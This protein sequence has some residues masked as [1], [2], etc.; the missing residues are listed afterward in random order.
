MLTLGTIADVLRATAG[1]DMAPSCAAIIVAAGNSLRMGTG[2]SKQFLTVGGVPVLA[3]TMLAFSASRYIDEIIVVARPEEIDAVWELQRSY[4]IPKISKVVAGG[5]SRSESVQNGFAAID[6]SIKYVAIHD[7][8][9]CLITPAMIKKVL[10]AAFLH[11]AASAACAVT[12]TVKLANKRGFI[13]KTVDRRKV[14]LAQTPQVFHADLYRAALSHA[15][16]KD[17]TDDNQLLE[18]VD[19]PVKLVDCGPENLK[20]THPDDLG[21]AE[22]ILARRREKA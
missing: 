11:R 13:E 5:A 17:L 10:R 8:A 20:I 7:G 9:R 19:F 3:R 6:K 21:R 12:D 4:N 14:Y 1:T 16:D 2:T 18:N 22:D 15:K